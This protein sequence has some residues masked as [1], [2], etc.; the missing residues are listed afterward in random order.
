MWYPLTRTIDWLHVH[1]KTLVFNYITVPLLEPIQ[2]EVRP[3]ITQIFFIHGS[4]S[5]VLQQSV[6]HFPFSC[7]R[8]GER[9]TEDYSEDY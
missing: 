2:V 7:L 5:F 6:Q 1:A 8:F 3:Y 4:S 9:I